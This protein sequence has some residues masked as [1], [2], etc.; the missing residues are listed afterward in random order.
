MACQSSIT[1]NYHACSPSPS[2]E[3]AACS[4]AAA[5]QADPMTLLLPAAARQPGESPRTS[6]PRRAPGWSSRATLTAALAQPT[7]S[8]HAA[9][10]QR[11]NSSPHLPLL[12]R[13]RA[14]AA[15][16]VL[17][18]RCNPEQRS[19]AHD[20]ALSARTWAPDAHAWSL[21]GSGRQRDD[22][23]DGG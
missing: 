3:S 1:A 22:S 11:S 16:Q 19:A 2:S 17:T 6:D 10:T 4:A 9:L 8:P 18:Q 14:L 5:G 21:S 15:G 7:R 13:E 20:T 12:C 23:L